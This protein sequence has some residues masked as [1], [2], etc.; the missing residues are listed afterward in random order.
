MTT[1]ATRVAT[2][3]AAELTR[4]WNAADGAAYGRA[5]TDDATFVD[6]RG[7]LHRSAAAIGSGHA[8]ILSTIYRDSRLSAEVLSARA[9]GPGIVA[10]VHFGLEA[11]HA[12]LPPHDGST[13]TLLAVEEPE[14][15][16]IAA[17][18]NTL[19]LAV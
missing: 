14:G 17:F 16:R 8:A 9:A 13:A 19:R 15:W 12:P 2:K 1:D 10:Q 7:G 6:I 3:L 18:Q 11:P 4:A 5:F